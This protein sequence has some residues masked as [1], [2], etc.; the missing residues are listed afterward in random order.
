MII[1]EAGVNHNGSLE[2][3]LRLVDAAAEAGADVVKFQ[4]FNAT[5]LASARAAKADYQQ[6]TT[7][8]DESQLEMLR[9][10]ELSEEAHVAV[11]RR[12]EERGVRFLSTPFDIDSLDLLIGRFGLELIK[13]GSGELTNAP[14]LL[15]A[16]QT[17]RA[18]I[19]STGMGT[20]EEAEAALG[21]LAFGYVWSGAAPRRAA[22]AK[23]LASAEG[24][25]AVRER[26]TLLHCTTE[27]PAPY[28]EVNLKAMDTLGQAFG[29]RVG[30][31]DH[32]PGGEVSIAAVARGAVVIEKHLTLDRGMEG[33][34]HAASLEPEDF[35]AMVTAIRHVEAALGDGLKAPA[36][37]ELKNRAVA[38][39]SIVAAQPI[40]PGETFGPDNLAVMRPGDGRSP[41]DYWDLFGRQ[42]DR[43]YAEHDPIA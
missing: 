39:K 40:A 19:L 15:A 2:L 7:K 33:P 29:V 24:L 14:L 4:T 10:L 23:A 31:S 8:A 13:L 12:C 20:L 42:A 25:A 34:D 5:R 22:F 37:S 6:R 35:A 1:A 43:S 16:A 32:T 28:A 41:M 38:R 30:Y 17:G 36:P 3:A 11:I 26:V 9:R 27:Y 21:V 18:M